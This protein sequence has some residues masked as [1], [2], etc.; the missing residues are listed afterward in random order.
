MILK[1]VEVKRETGNIELDK[2][3]INKKFLVSQMLT[4]RSAVL[5]YLD[6]HN[7][8]TNMYLNTSGVKSIGIVYDILYMETNNTMYKFEIVTT[9]VIGN[10]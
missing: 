10:E 8:I 3:N 5:Y 4:G 6:E 1:L 2:E 7:D 9:G